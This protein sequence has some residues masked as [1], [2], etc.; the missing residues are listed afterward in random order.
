MDLSK[1]STRIL[2]GRLDK[3]PDHCD[4]CGFKFVEYTVGQTHDRLIY[5]GKTK[6][7]LWA[8]M[9]E[10]CYAEYGVGL[11]LGKGQAYSART[12]LKV[13]G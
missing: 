9:C 11:G 6:M 1:V 10:P 3:L 13:Y 8:W 5:D 12:L 7:R 4:I 2:T